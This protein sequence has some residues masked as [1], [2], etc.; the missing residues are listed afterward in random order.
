MKK[1]ILIALATITLFACNPKNETTS[2]TDDAG[3]S[4]FK[5]NSKVKIQNHE[6]GH[7]CGEDNCYWCSFVKNEFVQIDLSTEDEDA[8]QDFQ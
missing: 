3:M 5:E 4:D 2:T 6:F 1:S 7:G 8:V